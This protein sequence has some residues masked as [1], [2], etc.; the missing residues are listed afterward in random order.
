MIGLWV[1]KE[2]KGEIAERALEQNRTVSNYIETLL[3]EHLKDNK[4]TG[5]TNTVTPQK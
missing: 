5:E 4:Q 1:R 2:L 3:M